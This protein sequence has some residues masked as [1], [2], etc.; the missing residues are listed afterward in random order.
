VTAPKQ[1]LELSELLDYVGMVLGRGIP[2]SVWVQ[3]EIAS[4]TDRRH[5]YLDLVQHD[6][7]GREVAK[8]RAN[9]WAS[10][11]F[12]L[13]AKFRKATGGRLK[14]DIKVLLQVV[15]DFHARYGFSLTIV[16]VA[17][18][19][20]VGDMQQKLGRLRDTLTREGDY[21]RNRALPLPDD[22]ARV[23][24]LSP[25][26]AAGLGDFRR[27][28]DRL[29][30]AGVVTF[31]YFEATFQGREASSSLLGALAA[32]HLAHAGQAF[33][34]LV[35]I[36]GGGASTDL[37]WLNDLEVARAVA[38]FPAPVVTGIG[39]ARDDTILDEV[40]AVRC[41]TPSKAVAW[42][43][44][45]VRDAA[46]TAEGQ[47]RRI[48]AV[49]REVLRTHT[50]EL[51][52]TRSRAYG[53]GGHA[54]GAAVGGGGSPHAAGAG[55]DASAD[56]GA[57]V[58]AGAGGG[59]GGDVGGLGGGALHAHAGVRD[60]TLDVTPVPGGAPGEV[61]AGRVDAERPGPRRR[62]TRRTNDHERESRIGIAGGIVGGGPGRRVLL[63][64]RVGGDDM[65]AGSAEYRRHYETLARIAQRLESGDAD[66]DEVLP[67]LEE[68]RVAYEACRARLE[69]V[70][71]ALGED[72]DGSGRRGR[73]RTKTTRTRRRGKRR[74]V[75]SRGAERGRTP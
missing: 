25:R 3:A 6:D 24:V 71:R 30:R 26:G 62:G 16:D 10:E 17:P 65:N 61:K 43:E 53:L 5:L 54:R 59:V 31:E 63:G 70:R 7:S 72:E 35:V 48:R 18:E 67:L 44:R 68:A 21:E 74:A 33:D 34:L 57:W 8:T 42:I 58:R 69:A 14:A 15:P 29:A 73:R 11:R 46:A 27:E 51:E 32:A 23:A 20:T 4:L 55:P 41:D 75:L 49:G 45:R 40:A 22:P 38:K 13:E 60:G 19:F 9:L 47:F 12:R 50:A 66:I 36:R 64:V 28:A 39:H 37:A 56:D 52:R 2:G 1:F